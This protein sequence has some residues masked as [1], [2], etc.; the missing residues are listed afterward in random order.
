MPPGSAIVE[1]LP[2]PSPVH[3]RGK[4]PSVGG[5]DAR[6]TAWWLWPH[7][8]SLD[9]PLVAVVWQ[10]WWARSLGVRLPWGQDAILGGGVWLIYLADRLADTA[11]TAPGSH[12][13]ARHDFYQRHHARIRFLAMAIF[14]GLS[15]FA[16]RLLDARQFI[17]GL[18]LFSLAGGY[19][20]LVHRR[21]ADGWARVFPKEAFVAGIF[22][23]GTLFFILGRTGIPRPGLLV[24]G[25]W[26]GGLC[27]CNCALITKWERKFA[28]LHDPASLL[29][30]FP[31][32]TAHLCA[33]CVGLAL[34]A[35]VCAVVGPWY[36]GGVFLPMA[37][38]ALLL[39]GLDRY[40]ARFSIDALRVLA[41]V[42][43]LTPWLCW[44]FTSR[45]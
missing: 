25:A 21:A 39:A 38:S 43:L 15:W 14:L 24:A 18:G 6:R 13:T 37:V 29:N 10:G 26:F 9:A 34:L 11:A 36:N 12:E 44:S 20:W 33:G 16:P 42:A 41:D 32:L 2:V 35:G 7:L 30:A 5:S 8:L 45:L 40:H 17:A 23:V 1:S 28:D 4:F 31:R 22:V 3:A 19:F 27:F